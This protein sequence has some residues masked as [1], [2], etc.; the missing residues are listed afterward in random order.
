M[1]EA[2]SNHEELP[3]V[4]KFRL[5]CYNYTYSKIT[6]HK[7]INSAIAF[8]FNLE[9]LDIYTDQISQV[10]LPSVVFSCQRL[11]T[12]KLAGGIVVDDIPGDVFFP[13][14]ETLKFNSISVVAD[15]PLGKLFSV[16][17]PN[18][19]I[20]HIDDCSLN[21]FLWGRKIKLDLKYV[22][23]SLKQG[24]CQN[25]LLS[26]DSTTIKV[27]ESQ[28][29]PT[30]KVLKQLV[31]F[32]TD[33]FE[34]LMF[35]RNGNRPIFQHLTHLVVKVEHKYFLCLT[36]LLEH[37]PN[38]TSLVVEKAKVV[39]EIWENASYWPYEYQIINKWDAPTTV[40]KCLVCSLETVQMKD[41]NGFQEMEVIKYFLQNALVMKKLVLYVARALSNEIKASILDQPR[42]SN[43]CKIEFRP[44]IS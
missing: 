25:S 32:D 36:S 14:L 22:M 23:A 38:L 21:I 39:R 11:K 7:W 15:N 31:L 1:D 2:S 43:Q 26:L 41:V 17:C 18:L 13:C 9:E 12:L 28:K 20:L 33:M 44:M 24:G 27:T 35:N 5:R 40:F 16:V 8:A 30:L 10:K 6:I 3:S 37:S 19:E 4:R 34:I 42:A 29:D